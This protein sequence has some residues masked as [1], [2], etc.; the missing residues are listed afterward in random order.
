M[1][2]LISDTLNELI[3]GNILDD[4]LKWKYLKYNIRKYTVDLYK[5]LRC[6]L[7]FSRFDDVFYFYGI[8]LYIYEDYFSGKEVA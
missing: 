7:L 5:R 6:S 8:N 3:N 2:E 1:N 4:Q